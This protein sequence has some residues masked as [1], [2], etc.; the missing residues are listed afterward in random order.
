MEKKQYLPPMTKAAAVRQAEMICGSTAGTFGVGN[1]GKVTEGSNDD[2]SDE[3]L[4][5]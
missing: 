2:W 4:N 1:D 3:N 5:W